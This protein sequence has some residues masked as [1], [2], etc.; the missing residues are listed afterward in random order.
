MVRSRAASREA[1]R[2]VR[3]RSRSQ[4]QRWG[5]PRSAPPSPVK[6]NARSRETILRPH[7]V[8]RA[9]G[10]S[11][12][13]EPL[14]AAEQAIGVGL[15]LGVDPKVGRLRGEAQ[16]RRVLHDLVLNDARL[17][18]AKG[19]L[20]ADQVQM[21]TLRRSQNTSQRTGATSRKTLIQCW[22]RRCFTSGIKRARPG[23]ARKSGAGRGPQTI[24]TSA[25]GRRR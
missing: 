17:A 11:D 23:T 7:L 5:A 9:S 16:E 15:G 4:R 12:R 20:C 8:R 24:V 10:R 1:G 6:R 25:P 2:S 3:V 13:Q 22:V 19:F 14:C 18:I 21:P